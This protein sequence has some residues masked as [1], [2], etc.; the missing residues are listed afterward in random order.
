MLVSTR[1]SSL[2]WKVNV[3]GTDRP[4]EDIEYTT[5]VEGEFGGPK[6][7]GDPGL[8]EPRVPKT[9][10]IQSQDAYTA[11]FEGSP[12]NTPDVNWEEEMVVA[13]AL[14]EHHTGGSTVEIDR[15]RYHTA[16]VMQDSVEIRFHVVHKSEIH[17]AVTTPCHAV[18][19]KR[20]GDRYDFVQTDTKHQEG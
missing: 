12:P 6:L 4:Y 9:E 16:G 7:G 11:F 14:G 3:E 15:I 20:V 13:V 18:R 10:V 5:I 8:L 17:A 2:T 1:R 19:C